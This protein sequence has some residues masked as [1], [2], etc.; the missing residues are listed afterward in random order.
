[1]AR[2]H[3]RF[4][5]SHEPGEIV[6]RIADYAELGFDHL[7]FHGPGDDQEQFLDDFSADVVPLLR[8]R[9]GEQPAAVAR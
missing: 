9:F 6:D 2:A 3:T 7:V 8:A 5:V 4:I 1:M